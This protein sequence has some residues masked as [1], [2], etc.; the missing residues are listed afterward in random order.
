MAVEAHQG[1][2]LSYL[3]HV[4]KSDSSELLNATL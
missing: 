4:P 1:V 2:S 3:F